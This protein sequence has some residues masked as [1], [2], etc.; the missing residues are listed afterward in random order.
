MMIIGKPTLLFV[1]NKKWE[2]KTAF[3]VQYSVMRITAKN[4]GVASQTDG[5][6]F[7]TLPNNWE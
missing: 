4:S 1:A 2:E 7:A 5:A 3:A 6:S